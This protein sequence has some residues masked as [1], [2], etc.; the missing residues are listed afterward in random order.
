MG[1]AIILRVLIQTRLL[2][3]KSFLGL[4]ISIGHSNWIEKV[5]SL[6]HMGCNIDEVFKL[7]HSEDCIGIMHPV[8]KSY[9]FIVR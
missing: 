2:I 1:Q 4:Y 8:S 6:I 7:Q 3:T 5:A 9:I